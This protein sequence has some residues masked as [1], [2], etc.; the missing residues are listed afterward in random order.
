MQPP[1]APAFHLTGT[2]E[3]LE[4]PSRLSFSFR[5]EPADADDVETLAE[6]SFREVDDATEVRLRQGPF[7]TDARRTLHQNGWS[8]SFDRLDEL[9]SARE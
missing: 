8:E 4:E 1:D 6:L 5:W 7:K 9:S 3:E 2:F